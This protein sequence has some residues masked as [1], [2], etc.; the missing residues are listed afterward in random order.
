MNLN[1]NAKTI[2]QVIAVDGDA[3]IVNKQVQT[4][5]AAENPPNLRVVPVETPRPA[6]PNA[7]TWWANI[8]AAL[9][10]LAEYLRHLET[11]LGAP[12]LDVG[13]ILNKVRT[14]TERVLRTLCERDGVSWGKAPPTL[15]N[16]KGPLR[17]KKV[18]DEPT[19]AHVETIQTNASPGSHDQKVALSRSHV[20]VTLIALRGLLDWFRLPA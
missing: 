4:E 1:I 18:F 19:Y 14:I 7:E 11:L 5:P 20:D 3:H 2:K 15:E 6:L 13:S 8:R 17:A 12:E 16:M 10:D 9:P